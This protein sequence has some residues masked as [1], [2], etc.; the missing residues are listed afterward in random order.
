MLVQ[1]STV[2]P[3]SVE[4]IWP[5]RIPLG[6][7]SL[8]IGEPGDGKTMNVCDIAARVTRGL[9]WPD[10]AAGVSGDAIILTAEDGL[11]DTLR[12]R[13]DR[14]GGDSTRVWV[15]QGMRVAGQEC[16]FNLESDLWALESVSRAPALASSASTR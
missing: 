10:G 11:A 6:K 8:V 13:I 1:L 5:A 15:L 3:E 14:Q 16:A 9:A 4:W 7:L 12:P 2:K